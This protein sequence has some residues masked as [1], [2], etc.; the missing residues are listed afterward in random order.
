MEEEFRCGNRLGY[1]DAEWKKRTNNEDSWI[2]PSSCLEM[3]LEM[4]EQV[5]DAGCR[6][7]K[8]EYTDLVI[9]SSVQDRRAEEDQTEIGPRAVRPILWDRLSRFGLVN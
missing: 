1:Q 6:N 4:R 8:G 5:R 3:R 9:L 2:S 7:E